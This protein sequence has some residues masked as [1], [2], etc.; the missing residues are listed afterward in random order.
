MD[1]NAKIY[2]SWDQ[3]HQDTLQLCNKIKDINNIKGIVCITRGGLVPCAIVASKLNIR[4]I[5]SVSIKSYKEN[6]TLSDSFEILVEPKEAMQDLGKDWI[7]IDELIDSGQTLNYIKTILPL[8]KIYTVY[9]KILDSNLV[10]AYYG[11][12]DKNQW[13]YFPWE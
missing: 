1:N 9:S 8:A 10:D 11:Y 3:F 6:L 7:V 4:K 2:I 5:E 12:Y 13:I